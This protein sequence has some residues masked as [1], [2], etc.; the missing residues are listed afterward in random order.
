M[1]TKTFYKLSFC[2]LFVLVSQLINTAAKAQVVTG[3]VTSSEGT[4]PGATIHFSKGNLGTTTDL[5]GAFSINLQDI[6]L[7]TLVISYI[8][9]DVQQQ[10]FDIKKGMNDLG[11]IILTPQSTNL[12]SVIVTGASAGSQVKAL[13]IKKSSLGIMD[14]LASDAIGK[15]PDRNA[16]EAIQRL[17]GVSIAR[18]AGEGRYVTVRGVP[19][20]WTAS[21]LNG[22]HMPSAGIDNQ[23]RR[24]QMDIFPSELIDFV[25]LSKAITPDIEGDNIGGSVNFITK[26]A[27]TKRLLNVNVAGGYGDLSQKGSYN[28]SIVYGDR[29]LKGKLGYIFSATIWDRAARINR[30]NLDYNFTLPDAIQSFSLADLQ[31][32]DYDLHRTTKGF[33]GGLDYA[34]NNNHKIY[35]KGVYSSY[36]DNQKVREEYFNY[37][38]GNVTYNTRNTINT[39]GLGSI[40]LGGNSSF[41]TKLKLDWAGSYDKSSSHSTN[42]QTGEVGYPFV[43]FTQKMQFNNLSSDGKMYLAMDSPN[44]IGGSIDNVMPNNATAINADSLKLNQVINIRIRN[45]EQDERFGFNLTHAT[46]AKLTLKMGGKFQHK[47]KSVDNAPNDVYLAGILGPAP[48]LSSMQREPYPYAGGFLTNL[49]SPYNNVILDHVTMKQVADLTTQ[50]SIDKYKLFTYQR[51]SANN[52]TGATKY[53][54]GTENVYAGYVMADYKL[55]DKLTIIGGIRNEYIS[56]TYN[57]NTVLKTTVDTTTKTTITPKS[58]DYNYNAFLPM[59][60]LKYAATLNDIASL[61][62]TR[63]YTRPDFSALNPATNQSDI[64]HTITQGNPDLKPTFSTNFDAM[65]EHYFGKIGLVNAGVFYKNIDN[66]IYSNGGAEDINGINYIVSQP[67]NLDK[68]WL[69]GFEVGFSKRFLNMPGFWSGFGVDANY[70]YI[71]SQTEI[72]RLTTAANVTPAVYVY[73]K[74]TLPQQSKHVLNASLFYERKGLMLRLAANYKG[75]SVFTINSAYGT[76]HYVYAAKNLTMDFSGSYVINDKIRVFLELNNVLNTATRFFMGTY[77]RVYQAEWYGRRGQVGV[78]LKLFN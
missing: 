40:E 17:P 36:S 3:V 57:S 41:G 11:P 15:L 45:S 63:T 43:N 21:L 2:G 32:R 61:A 34:F 69:Y 13:S 16:A 46:T 67:R 51:D 20:A 42:P 76:D 12:G 72:P 26:T 68:A 64:T 8:G 23:D 38:A 14:V 60:H 37:N 50:E 49:G 73:D 52:A 53:Y 75:Q 77:D 9:Y 55:N 25:Q 56:A 39:I 1:N 30:Y 10:V 31:L 59:V 18:D 44:G 62:I 28:A 58:Q 19:T 22:N 66:F 35:V 65:Y 24:I 54:N 47:V 78:S 6:G 4:L 74:T 33:N 48:S 29:I 27:P 71:N 70:T 5:Q 7:D